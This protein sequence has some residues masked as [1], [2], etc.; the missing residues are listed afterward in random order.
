MTEKN[1]KLTNAYLANL[2]VEYVKIHN[3]HWN[4]VGS[5]FKAVHEYLESLYD[6]FAD[7]MDEVAEL[8]RMAGELPVASMKGY[9]ELAT[10]AEMDSQEHSI[11]DVV[12]LVLADMELLRAQ[13]LELRAAASE[14]DE[15]TV[16]NAMEDHVANYDKTIW[17][18]KSM[19]K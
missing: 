8:L 4:V 17:F 11:A 15:F 1:V 16:A 14:A 10:V 3:L 9:L 13:A 5:Q 2:A 18:L 19:T 7:S 6:A 12:K